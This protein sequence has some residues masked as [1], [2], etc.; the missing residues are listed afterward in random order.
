MRV[1]IKI[2]AITLVT[3]ICWQLATSGPVFADSLPFASSDFGGVEYDWTTQWTLVP[4]STQFTMT[5]ADAYFAWW[6]YGHESGPQP[7]VLTVNLITPSVEGWLG[8]IGGPSL[9]AININPNALPT[10]NEGPGELILMGSYDAGGVVAYGNLWPPYR[11]PYYGPAGWTEYFEPVP[12]P[13]TLT[14]L[15]SALLGLGAFYLR[16][17]RAKV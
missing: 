7:P 10:P 17:R 12:E 16:R 15:T 2:A 5:D 11:D 9:N 6:F 4:P 13:T 8:L 14:L 1:K 3:A